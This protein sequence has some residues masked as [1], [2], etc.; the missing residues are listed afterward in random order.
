L[1]TRTGFA[2]SKCSTKGQAAPAAALRDVGARP[3]RFALI[4]QV[5]DTR[6][7]ARRL[8]RGTAL[9]CAGRTDTRACILALGVRRCDPVAGFEPVAAGASRHGAQRPSLARRCAGRS[10]APHTSA[11]TTTASPGR[12]SPRDSSAPRWPPLRLSWP[13]A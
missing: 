13:T 10:P 3:E 9:G 12:K 11:R 1:A 5:G 7:R 4:S 6:N 8:G 2:P